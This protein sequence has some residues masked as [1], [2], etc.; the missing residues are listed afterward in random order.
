M[1]RRTTGVWEQFGF[2]LNFCNLISKFSLRL[3]RHRSGSLNHG[4]S[5]TVCRKESAQFLLEM[6]L[7]F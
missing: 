2:V 3:L 7:I 4:A 1:Q 5:D 6:V